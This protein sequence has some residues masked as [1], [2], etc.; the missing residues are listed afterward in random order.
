[1]WEFIV[2]GNKSKT[3]KNASHNYQ[4][5][6]LYFFSISR[7]FP[8]GWEKE[9]NWPMRKLLIFSQKQNKKDFFKKKTE[10]PNVNLEED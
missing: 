8:C 6:K 7:T 2:F 10:D 5:K 1:M 3:N 9:R 4:A